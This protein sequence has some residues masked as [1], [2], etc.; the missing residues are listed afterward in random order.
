M[1]A[2]TRPDQAEDMASSPRGQ[3]LRRLRAGRPP[4]FH[5]RLQLADLVH[6][7]FRLVVGDGID[8]GA[9]RAGRE[10]R[11]LVIVVEGLVEAARTGEGL[12]V[13]EIL[14]RLR[15]GACGE[16]LGVPGDDRGPRR[17]EDSLRRHPTC[18]ESLGVG[19]Q[20]HVERFEQIGALPDEAAADVDKVPFR[21]ASLH[22]RLQLGVI[23]RR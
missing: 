15:P 20:R 21:L 12:D 6:R 5:V 4:H 2:R 23:R 8:V 16:R 3:E 1:I 19:D 22:H 10:Q 9:R 13:P 18:V 17:G 7:E 14:P 11:G